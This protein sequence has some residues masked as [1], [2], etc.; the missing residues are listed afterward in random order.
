M[1]SDLLTHQ[2]D[3][4][5]NA[6]ALA[7]GHLEFL[8]RNTGLTMRGDQDH[9]VFNP[10]GVLSNNRHFIG[11]TRMEYQPNG[12]ATTEGQSLQIIGFAHMYLATKDPVWLQKAIWCWDA[13]VNHYYTTPMPSAPAPWY[14][15]W[16]INGKEPVLA[17]WPLDPTYPTHAGFKGIPFNWTNGRVSIP[18]GAPYWGE[19]LEVV[20]FAFDGALAWNAINASVK[21]IN[22][23][24]STN[25]DEDGVVYDLDWLIDYLGRKIDWDG[26][27]LE[28]VASEPIGTVQLKNTGLQGSHKLNFANCQPV[29]HGG[30]MLPRNKP[31]HNRPLR[32]PVPDDAVSNASDGE[33]WFAEACW[34]LWEITKETKY[35]TAFGCVIKTCQLYADIDR[36]DMFFRRSTVATSPFTDGISYSYTYP[37]DAEAIFTRDATGLI[38][39]DQPISAQ[40]TMEQQSIWFRVDTD[41]VLKLELGGIT[42]ASGS[43]INWRPVVTLAT[44]K[45]E[46]SPTRV[47]YLAPVPPSTAREVFA[48]YVPLSQF[49]RLADANGNAYVIADDRSVVELERT[50]ST[51]AWSQSILGDRY[52]MVNH[53]EMSVDDS[54]IVGFWLTEEE[55][56]PL[57][58]LTYRSGEDPMVMRIS[59]AKKWR[60]E[61]NLPATNENWSTITI[62][63]SQM[64]LMDEQPDVDPPEE[65]DSW[66]AADASLDDY[67][68]N[69]VVT[70][71]PEVGVI[72][73]R[74]FT[75][76]R[77]DMDDDGGIEIGLVPNTTIDR[78][79]YKSGQDDYNLRVKDANGWRW[80]IMVPKTNDVWS[81]LM[82]PTANFRLSSYQPDGTGER[83]DTFV[84]PAL[85]SYT[86]LL[87]DTPVDTTGWIEIY[88]VNEMPPKDNSGGIRPTYP[89]FE[90]VVDVMFYP[91]TD[92]AAGTGWMEWYCFNALPERFNLDSAYTMKF[93]LTASAFE[94]YLARMGDCVVEK[95]REDNLAYTP[96]VIPFSNNID[97]YSMLF[98]GWRGMPYPGYQYPYIWVEDGDDVRMTNMV[99]FMYDAQVAYKN[100]F[101][102]NGPVA[103]A[104][105]WNR[106]DSMSYGPA[107][108]FAFT[109]W[110]DGEPWSGYQPRAF[111]GGALA[112]Y[113]LV[114]LGKPVPANLSEYVMNWVN[115]LAEF[116]EA[117]G[118]INPTEFPSDALPRAPEDDFTGHMSGLWLAGACYAAMAGGPTPS[119]ETVIR[120]TLV[121]LFDNYKVVLPDHPMNGSWSPA[122]RANTDNGMFFGF[123]S[124][125]ILRGLG[126]YLQYLQLR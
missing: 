105:Y 92:P 88:C 48:R 82:L 81:E 67:G 109:H 29:E 14:C 107:D 61:F 21:G 116:Q 122:V 66:L 44:E 106:W 41:S 16:I 95:Y 39:I 73:G 56:I 86:M 42:K 124:G 97:A 104:Y 32:V 115:W 98:D 103:A 50:K 125:E 63:K 123:W 111:L 87:D 24:G 5:A 40:T 80:W 126:V 85:A 62:D 51:M 75:G 102:I 112:W 89:D 25:W 7:Y 100:K 84:M 53:L 6:I 47:D 119:T 36:F 76:I 90:T 121:E 114:R 120:N 117:N 55:K 18:H 71:V 43:P 70:R 30:Y 31:W 3:F 52:G 1:K 26:N 9:Y 69:T 83:P 17:N 57:N 22:A 12:D 110:G 96:G 58:T 65:A 113:E 19:Y 37:S 60:W 15:N 46:D 33:Q 72:D 49:V 74:D 59:D 101:G 118:G 108:T 91:K 38:E 23:D 64:V 10:D 68:A 99:N 8:N 93:S 45:K 27:I 77:V 13:Y 2:E 94:G 78:I 35:K 54:A 79:V 20:S 4:K 28:Q 11:Y 34:M